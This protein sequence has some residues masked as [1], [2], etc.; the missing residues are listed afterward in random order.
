MPAYY[1]YVG[2]ALIALVTALIRFFPFIVF[3]GEGED[4][5]E[6]IKYMGQVLPPAIMIT[7]VVYN[8]RKTQL[9]QSPYGLPELLAMISIIIFHFR[10][11]N[12]FLSIL[13]GTV[14]YMVLLRIA[15]PF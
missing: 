2:I 11:K 3:K 12:T 9:G 4:L 14:I 8:L 5:P 7:L 15:W 13:L 10:F 6:N 1:Y